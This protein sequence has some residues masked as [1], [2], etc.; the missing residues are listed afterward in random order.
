MRRQLAGRAWAEF[1]TTLPTTLTL[2]L[3]MQRRLR[4][5]AEAELAR[6]FSA[7]YDHLVYAV[8][9]CDIARQ[10]VPALGSPRGLAILT[11]TAASGRAHPDK[12][13]DTIGMIAAPEL[14]QIMAERAASGDGPRFK[15][16]RLSHLTRAC[17][18]GGAKVLV[19]AFRAA[20]GLGLRDLPRE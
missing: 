17:E 5:D 7:S 13:I 19:K 15:P 12:L 16:A 9:V 8:A 20:E 10:S 11:I 1:P 6:T 2:L 18:S 3:G 14:A 4:V